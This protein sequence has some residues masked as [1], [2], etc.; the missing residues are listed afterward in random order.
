MIKGNIRAAKKHFLLATI[1]VLLNSCASSVKISDKENLDETIR[2]LSQKLI[3]DPG[4]HKYATN[5]VKI[6]QEANQLSYNRVA[7]LRKENR[8]DS[9]EQMVSEYSTIN[10]RQETVRA[11][12][13][14]VI[15]G[16]QQQLPIQ[17]VNTE[18]AETKAKI[19]EY[20]Y[21]HAKKILLENNK[22]SCQ[23]AFTEFEKARQYSA[24]HSDLAQFQN[25]AKEK[26]IFHILISTL[27][28]S[29]FPLSDDYLKNNIKLE[30][31]DL[32]TEWIKYYD[33]KDNR[34][35]YDCRIIIELKEIKIT[36][37]KTTTT[38]RNETK[39]IAVGCNNRFDVI[40][41]ALEEASQ[42]KIAHIE[43]NT[44]FLQDSSKRI[45]LTKPF[46]VDYSFKFSSY[47]AEGDNSL[48][49]EKMRELLKTNPKPIPFPTDHE[50]VNEAIKSLNKAVTNIILNTQASVNN[51]L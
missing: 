8:P 37:A 47:V 25:D 21:T 26:G 13:P 40:T 20:Y 34:S 28:N 45:I 42:E 5:L 11:I 51:T 39:T 16:Q 12:S 32:N 17:D 30:L 36:P 44:I 23:K 24:Q 31:Q 50:L 4:N 29:A 41:C 49:S 22:N 33:Q 27:N 3:K 19:A 43:G 1:I 6:Y 48:L 7:E 14:I 10:K 35:D 38:V 15:D 46:A 18:I 9:W 2:I